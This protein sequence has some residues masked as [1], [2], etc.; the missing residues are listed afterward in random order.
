LNEFGVG[1]GDGEDGSDGDAVDTNSTS[2]TTTTVTETGAGWA[3]ANNGEWK[4]FGLVLTD[5]TTGRR[6][7]RTIKSNTA[8]TITWEGAVADSGAGWT[9]NIGGIR[10]QV[11]LNVHSP[12]KPFGLQ[13]LMA[14]LQDLLGIL[15]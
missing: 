7:Y 13:Q 14:I 9:F 8:D 12:G 5:R 6:Y 15:T 2:D 11:H 4:S 1:W 3:T 10:T